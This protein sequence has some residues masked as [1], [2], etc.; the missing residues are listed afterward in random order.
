MT[1]IIIKA[2]VGLFI[3]LVL[4]ELINKKMKSKKNTKSFIRISCSLIG[5]VILVFTGIDFFKYL[6]SL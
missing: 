2:I 5:I 4:P 3:W 6:L 1:G